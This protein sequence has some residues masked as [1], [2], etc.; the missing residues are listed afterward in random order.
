MQTFKSKG[1]G[2]ILLTEAS[3]YDKKFNSLLIPIRLGQSFE[4]KYDYEPGSSNIFWRTLNDKGEIWFEIELEPWHFKIVSSKVD[5]NPKLD[6]SFL[7]RKLLLAVRKINPHFLREGRSWLIET[8]T[9]FNL[10]DD[11]R[12]VPILVNNLAKWARVDAVELYQQSF[13]TQHD[14][15]IHSKTFTNPSVLKRNKNYHSLEE[16][17]HLSFFFENMLV[18][19]FLDSKDQFSL[20]LSDRGFDESTISE[21]NSLV[22]KIAHQENIDDLILSAYSYQKFLDFYQLLPLEIISSSTW[23]EKAVFLP[24]ASTLNQNLVLLI[25]NLEENELQAFVKESN[26]Y[27]LFK[28]NTIADSLSYRSVLPNFFNSHGDYGF[29][30]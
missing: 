21:H 11:F 9:S 12:A 2:Q 5:L 22:E 19:F 27:P 29:L 8:Q 14:L 4:T 10:D 20:S 1:W 15:F 13:S 25:S 24:I 17:P 3:L 28:L 23:R 18:G 30:H 6:F 26:F 16:F 7:V